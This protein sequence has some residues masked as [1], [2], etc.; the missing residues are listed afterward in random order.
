MYGPLE[1]CG[2]G[3]LPSFPP[4]KSGT[5]LYIGILVYFIFNVFCLYIYIYFKFIIQLKYKINNVPLTIIIDFGKYY[6]ICLF[7]YSIG[8]IYF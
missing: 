7:H 2:P 3:H 6:I 5:D 1:M 8:L 4:S